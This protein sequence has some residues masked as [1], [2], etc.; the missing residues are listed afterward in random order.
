LTARRARRCFGPTA[1]WTR[2]KGYGN[3]IVSS[4]NG[5]PVYLHDVANVVDTVQDERIKMRFWVRGY[6][7]PAA[8]VVVA[9][10]RQAG[11]NA[12]AVV[13]SVLN[14]LPFISAELP[15]SVRVTPIYD[16]SQTI[17]NSVDDVQATLHRFRSCGFR[18]L[19]VSREG[20]PT[21]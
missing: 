10:N 16:R 14:L 5:A 13:K 4:T 9:V 2:A 3:L 18:D 12:V 20:P 8:T 17:V 7:E 11:S 6:D 19:H 1:N 15:G 21:R